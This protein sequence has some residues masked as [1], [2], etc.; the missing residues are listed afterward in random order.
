MEI[1]RRLILRLRCLGGHVLGGGLGGGGGDEGAGLLVATH[2]VIFAA[3]HPESV[4]PGISAV[5]AVE[6]GEGFGGVGD[7]GVEIE[8]L[9]IGEVGVGHGRGNRGPVGGE[10]ATKAVGVVA[11]TEVVVAGFGVA[12]FAFKFVVLRA[13]VGVGAFAAV[14]VEVGVIARYTGVAGEDARSA[15]HV[16]NII[17][18]AAAGGKHGD[19]LASEENILGGGV[20]R[21]IGFG[22]DV[23]AGTVPIEFAASF[24]DVVRIPGDGDQRSGVIPITIPG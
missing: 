23:A 18:R 10:P 4:G 17:E 3:V 14:G 1:A 11:S 2:A 21:S 6:V 24:G 19:A 12:L 8:G 16:F 13:G 15:E 7:H 20:A 9:R 5:V 22:Q